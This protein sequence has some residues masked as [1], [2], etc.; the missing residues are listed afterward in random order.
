MAD[1]SHTKQKIQKRSFLLLFGSC[2]VFS[3]NC[4]LLLPALAETVGL[5]LSFMLLLPW[6]FA[7]L[8]ASALFNRNPFAF[9]NVPLLPAG[10]CFRLQ[11]G[12]HCRYRHSSSPPP[13]EP[14][15]FCKKL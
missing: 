13:R 7:L 4:L 3:C 15:R 14:L 5:Q 9:A 11:S 10:F 1:F 8:P 12:L 2:E 6:R